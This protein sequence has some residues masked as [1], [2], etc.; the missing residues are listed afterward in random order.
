MLEHVGDDPNAY[1]FAG[2]PLDPNVGFAY[3]RA[4]WM[5]PQNGRFV[6][7]DPWLGSAWEPATLHRYTYAASEPVTRTDPSG[8]F[9]L[10]Q[11][12][13][14]VAVAL[15]VVNVGLA[16]ARGDRRGAVK[17]AALG[18]LTIFG[19][20]AALRF[21]RWARAA[22]SGARGSTALVKSADAALDGAVLRESLFGP[23]FVKA[24]RIFGIKGMSG[25]TFIRSIVLI[26]AR[27]KGAVSLFTLIKA[28]EAE[29]R[30]A[31][32]KKLLIMGHAVINDKIITAGV[33]IAQRLGF[34]VRWI[35][36][37]TIE[38]IKILV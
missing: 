30:A 8:L 9:T 19:P 21:I 1:L 37:E 36:P 22:Y 6:S 35:N 11:A 18:L 26:E 17:E 38:L 24:F 12:L 4:R 25:T 15:T 29:A 20:L 28:L 13:T 34:Q 3:H 31:G 5:D 32:A 2:E 7:E 10:T 27:K 33:R 23:E 14:V 16:L